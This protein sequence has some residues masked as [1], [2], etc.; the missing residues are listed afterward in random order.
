MRNLRIRRAWLLCIALGLQGLCATTAQ[1]VVVIG[2]YQISY[3]YHSLASN[4]TFAPINPV[5]YSTGLFSVPVVVPLATGNYQLELVAGSE[6]GNPVDQAVFD[7]AVG[8]GELDTF[9]SSLVTVNNPG[10]P[11]Y[12]SGFDGG[13]TNPSNFQNTWFYAATFWVGTSEVTG[14]GNRFFGLGNTT[15]IAVA[16]GEQL[17]LFWNDSFTKDNLGGSTVRV[18][19]LESVPEP[20]TYALLLAG[21]GLLGFA[22]RRLKPH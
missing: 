15:N 16:A 19:L 8:P 18:S 10:A 6:S 11:K 4:A 20:G 14:A 13:A 9:W 17:W 1:A 3:L 22:A 7:A 12:Q 21:L 2:E 5:E